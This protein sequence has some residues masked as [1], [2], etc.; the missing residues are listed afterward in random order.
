MNLLKIFPWLVV[1][2]SFVFAFITLSVRTPEGLSFLEFHI[3]FFIETIMSTFFIGAATLF[4]MG[5][6]GFKLRLRISYGLI[7]AGL[8]ILGI[9]QLQLP[10][11]NYY[12][13]WS[14][15]WVAY[16][17]I[18]V[19]N[20]ITG[21]LI[22]TGVR[23]FARMLDTKTIFTSYPFLVLVTVLVAGVVVFLPHGST[24]DP[25]L[26]EFWF[27]FSTSLVVLVA[28]SVS[29]A[30]I[31]ILKVKQ[32]AGASFTNAL[33]WLFLGMLFYTIAS[34]QVLVLQMVGF[35]N[36]YVNFGFFFVP[37]TISGIL[38]LRAGYVFNKITL[39]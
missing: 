1:V 2:L 6:W 34:W 11:F 12:N 39:Y 5:F 13:L 29:F 35:D 18:E 10:Y 9:S 32:K 8:I 20:I 4:T 3:P 19:P 17:G 15:A 37:W 28:T 36:S 27:D 7:C 22:F 25:N 24:I 23:L 30:T 33:A 21:L 14:S 26:P 38:L 16:G 31:T